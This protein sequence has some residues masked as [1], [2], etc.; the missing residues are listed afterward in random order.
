[1]AGWFELWDRDRW[2]KKVFPQQWSDGPNPRRSKE[3]RS[4]TSITNLVLSMQHS[5]RFKCEPMGAI[6]TA[7]SEGGATQTPY[8][9]DSDPMDFLIG[10]DRDPDALAAASKNEGH[11]ERFKPIRGTFADMEAL[12]SK[13]GTMGILLD[14]GV[15]SPQIDRPSGASASGSG[16]TYRHAD[17]SEP[18]SRCSNTH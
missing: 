3:R 1:M 10:I 17:G 12:A 6:W 14:L 18:A 9:T 13:W 15:S 5:M 11:G 4:A 2:E 8:S 7:H 16:R